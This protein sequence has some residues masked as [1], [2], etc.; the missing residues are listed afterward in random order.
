[1]KLTLQGSGRNLRERLVKGFLY[2]KT[3]VRGGLVHAFSSPR[4]MGFFTKIFCRRF[5]SRF[6]KEIEGEETIYSYRI[7]NA[8]N[9]LNLFNTFNDTFDQNKISG[10]G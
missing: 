10:V 5:F 2:R 6:L 1:V 4:R 3:L 9:T 7:S 8:N